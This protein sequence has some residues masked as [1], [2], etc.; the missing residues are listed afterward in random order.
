MAT[1]WILVQ[2]KIFS[3]PLTRRHC[4]SHFV[5]ATKGV[6]KGK[7]APFVSLVSHFAIF[8]TRCA[9][10]GGGRERGLR[11]ETIC[12]ILLT[13]AETDPICSG[14]RTQKLNLP[15]Q[16]VPNVQ[17]QFRRSYF[18][19]TVTKSSELL[20]SFR[21]LDQNYAAWS[22]SLLHEWEG[23]QVLECG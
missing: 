22:R 10:P 12:N 19:G 15:E 6:P 3:G 11:R 14:F 1:V 5:Q 21:I 7:K 23:D 20:N 4:L 9:L 8:R 2:T 16:K 17:T 13:W 18:I